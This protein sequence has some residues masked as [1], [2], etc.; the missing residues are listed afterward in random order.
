[1]N[2]IAIIPARGGSKRIPRKNIRA[3]LGRPVLAWSIAAARDSGLFERIIV[4]TDDPEIAEVAA[5]EGA[6]APFLR[7]AGLADDYAGVTEVLLD[8]LRRLWPD[9]NVPEFTCLIYATAPLLRAMDLVAG[10][11]LLRDTGADYSISIASFPAPIDRALQLEDGKVYMRLEANRLVRSQ[12]LPEAYH[13][14]GQFC[15][16]RS[17]SWLSGKGVFQSP[18]APVILPRIRVQDIDTVE[19]WDRAQVLARVLAEMGE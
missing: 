7:E 12:D 1:M 10:F 18:T 4:S 3:F 5:A 6:E 14:A 11:N 13:D 9:S 17:N 8:T 16:G 15:W 19:D 2:R